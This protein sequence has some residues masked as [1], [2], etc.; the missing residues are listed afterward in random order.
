M[1]PNLPLGVVGNLEV[2][3][4]AFGLMA[5]TVTSQMSGYA[6]VGGGVCGKASDP[7]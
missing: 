4:H 3:L 6:Q 5:R 2:S 7:S 1:I